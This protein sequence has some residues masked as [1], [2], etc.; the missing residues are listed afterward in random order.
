M[1]RKKRKQI[2]KRQR[3]QTRKRTVRQRNKKPVVRW[4][5]ALFLLLL[6]IIL[7]ISV[8]TNLFGIVTRFTG[9]T[10]H[11]L[12]GDDSIGEQE[13]H[14][15]GEDEAFEEMERKIAVYKRQL[16]ELEIKLNDP[17]KAAQIASLQGY[18]NYL[19]SSLNSMKMQIAEMQ[20]E[21]AEQIRQSFNEMNA[22]VMTRATEMSSSFE[23]YKSEMTQMQRKLPDSYKE[24]TNEQKIENMFRYWKPTQESGTIANTTTTDSSLGVRTATS[25]GVTV[26]IQN[27]WTVYYEDN[28]NNIT[29][30]WMNNE[31]LFSN[32]DVFPNLTRQQFTSTSALATNAILVTTISSAKMSEIKSYFSTPAAWSTALDEHSQGYFIY[33]KG[34]CAQILILGATPQAALYGVIDFTRSMS[35]RSA[36]SATWSA[37][38][39]L[40]WPDIEKRMVH[41]FLNSGTNGKEYAAFN[42]QTIQE[43]VDADTNIKEMIDAMVWLHTTHLMHLANFEYNLASNANLKSGL[44][45]FVSYLNARHINYIPQ[46]LGMH[47]GISTDFNVSWAEGLGVFDEQFTITV[48]TTKGT[49]VNSSLSSTL[50]NADD[51]I[52]V[53]V[54]AY[55]GTDNSTLNK[56]TTITVS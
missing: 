42:K 13:N 21:R 55:D 7:S 48:N 25:I 47:G 5:G 38:K 12:T 8:S 46:I 35:S 50:Y 18:V 39:V 49:M 2:R 17:T 28:T 14:Q 6:V 29:S 19:Q 44:T 11:A 33:C 26:A 31:I 32:D 24:L 10:T 54:Y 27:P 51:K 52:N 16:N 20:G 9:M 40:N 43:I 34:S 22:E 36:T 23:A 15:K 3:K 1:L 41:E 4:K 37:K 45:S 30:L 53:T 56:S